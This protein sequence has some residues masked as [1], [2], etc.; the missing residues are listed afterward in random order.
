MR[1]NGGLAVG[2]EARKRECV[3]DRIL[4]VFDVAVCFVGKG[5][6]EHD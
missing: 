6:P 4:A 5:K 1:R 2:W 3:G